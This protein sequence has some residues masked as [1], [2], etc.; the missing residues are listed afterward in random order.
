MGVIRLF[1]F[2]SSM[3][4][5]VT[6]YFNCGGSQRSRSFEKEFWGIGNNFVFDTARIVVNG[7]CRFFNWARRLST[8][9][10]R[11]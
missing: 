5:M 4:R 11:S 2:V 1:P 6:E 7:Y 10:R 3:G 8:S 9:F